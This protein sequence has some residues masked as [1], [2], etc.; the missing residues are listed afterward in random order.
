MNRQQSEVAVH[1]SPRTAHVGS[2]QKSLKSDLEAPHPIKD[3]AASATV[4]PQTTPRITVLQLSCMAQTDALK[5]VQGRFTSRVYRD[6]LMMRRLKVSPRSVGTIM[7]MA[8]A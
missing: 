4:N 2:S 7:Y 6:H 1:V 5:Q 8:R 3:A